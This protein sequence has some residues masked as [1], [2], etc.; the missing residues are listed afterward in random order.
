MAHDPRK[1]HGSERF[2]GVGF[3]GERARDRQDAL[4]QMEGLSQ[5]D[6]MIALLADL[7]TEQR[8]TNQLLEWFADRAHRK[9]SAG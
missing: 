4:R 9:D 6:K 3:K 5:N 2:L 1:L 7:V 8:R